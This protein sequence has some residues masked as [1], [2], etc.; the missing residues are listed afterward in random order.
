MSA[1]DERTAPAEA[2]T[3]GPRCSALIPLRL[4]GAPVLVR[5]PEPADGYWTGRCQCGHP[6]GARLCAACAGLA[7]QS[8]CRACREAAEGAHDCPLLDVSRNTPEKTP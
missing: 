3:G 4:R 5:C 7:G 2:A 1:V 6:R 8:G